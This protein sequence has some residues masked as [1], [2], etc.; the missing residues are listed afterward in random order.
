MAKRLVMERGLSGVRLII[1][2]A[3]L[4]LIEN[5]AELFAG[6]CA[7]RDACGPLARSSGNAGRC[8]R[9]LAVSHG[10]TLF[11]LQEERR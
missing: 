1:L 7:T 9:S 4:E 3:C 6:G 11:A 8:R 2:D 5:A 10:V